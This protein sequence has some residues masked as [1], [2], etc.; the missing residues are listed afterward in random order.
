M[1]HMY[2]I[3]YMENPL[4]THV[5]VLNEIAHPEHRPNVGGFASN[6]PATSMTIKPNRRPVTG[7]SGGARTD[8][9]NRPAARPAFRHCSTRNS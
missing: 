6:G 1:I 2:N 5:I 3:S 7:S 4:A 9:C 8:L